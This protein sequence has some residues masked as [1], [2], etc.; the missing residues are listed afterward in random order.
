MVR[1]TVCCVSHHLFVWISWL[2]ESHQVVKCL[3]LKYPES[4]RRHVT[5]KV[6]EEIC[7]ES[8]GREGWNLW[9]SSERHLCRLIDVISHCW[10]LANQNE[11]KDFNFSLWI[12]VHAILPSL[13]IRNI[14]DMTDFLLLPSAMS[15]SWHADSVCNCAPTKVTP[16]HSQHHLANCSN[17]CTTVCKAYVPHMLCLW[18]ICSDKLYVPHI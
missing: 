9:K 1:N 17:H 12:L 8:R 14:Y 18:I 6:I 10:H 5:G 11:S 4:S 15:L 3:T 13:T 16:P 7:T 2:Q